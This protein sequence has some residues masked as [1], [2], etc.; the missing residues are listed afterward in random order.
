MKIILQLLVVTTLLFGCA[1]PPQP[2]VE[3]TVPFPA[4]A[5][6][7]DLP[8]LK[9]IGIYPFFRDV[10]GEFALRGLELEIE[11][12]LSRIPSLK[13][14][15]ADELA[16]AGATLFRPGEEVF[17]P[18]STQQLGRLTETEALLIGEFLQSRLNSVRPYQRPSDGVSCEEMQL[19]IE[20]NPRL[21]RTRTGEILYNRKLNSTRLFSVCNDDPR[22]L[23]IQEAVTQATVELAA[24]LRDQLGPREESQRMMLMGSDG[25][26]Q[27]E[28]AELYALGVK[29]AKHG[30][31]DKACE[32]WRRQAREHGSDAASLQYNLGLCAESDGDIDMAKEHYDNAISRSSA[33]F[34]DLLASSIRRVQEKIRL[35]ERGLAQ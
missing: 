4:A 14:V 9:S 30:S 34:D 25:E 8:T 29:F 3:V 1:T 7:A 22:E 32:V 28:A 27:R 19:N 12:Q 26:Y 13:V 21:L 11:Q 10:R 6:G 2:P 17:D 18:I 35:R 5:G 16:R 20:I 33:N 24:K 31:W 23:K 15:S